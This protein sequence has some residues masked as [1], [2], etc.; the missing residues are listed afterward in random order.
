[1][2]VS[3]MILIEDEARLAGM[4]AGKSLDDLFE[5]DALEP[6]ELSDDEQNSQIYFLDCYEG[7]AEELPDRDRKLFEDLVNILFWTWRDEEGKQ[8]VQTSLKICSLETALA[9]QTCRILADTFD[10][11]NRNV[12]EE[13]F[14]PS[15]AFEEFEEFWSYIEEWRH[16]LKKAADDNKHLYVVVCI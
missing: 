16:L 8:T 11:L 14:E 4:L 13:H 10:A 12:F 9:P 1:M 3:F 15:H 7:F 5:A 2:S 6:E